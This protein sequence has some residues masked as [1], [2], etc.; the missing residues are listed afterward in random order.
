MAVCITGTLPTAMPFPLSALV[1]LSLTLKE[2]CLGLVELAFP[3][4]RP[5]IRDDYRTA[6]RGREHISDVSNQETQM[7][8]HLFKVCNISYTAI[9]ELILQFYTVQNHLS[10][11]HILTVTSLISV[12]HEISPD[13]VNTNDVSSLNMKGVWFD[14]WPGCWWIVPSEVSNKVFKTLYVSSK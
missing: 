4:S 14:L 10:L 9:S 2:V 3:D 13:K 6:V 5:S 1:P 7:W 11:L 12:L 8:A